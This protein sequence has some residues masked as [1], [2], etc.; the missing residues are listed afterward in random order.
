VQ[1]IVRGDLGDDAVDVATD[2]ADDAK[3]ELQQFAAHRERLLQLFVV[4]QMRERGDF[5]ETAQAF[6][7][8][9]AVFDAVVEHFLAQL[10]Q[11][12]LAQ[13]EVAGQG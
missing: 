11:A 13:H 3:F 2:L 6:L 10:G 1:G 9:Q 12:Q 7:L 4:R 8:A 5:I